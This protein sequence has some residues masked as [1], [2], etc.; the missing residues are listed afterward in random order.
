V[1][2]LHLGGGFV[3]IDSVN[4]E[5][6]DGR[7]VV[8]WDDALRVLRCIEANAADTEDVER[9]DLVCGG[10]ELDGVLGVDAAL[11]GV[12]AN[13]DFVR[14]ISLRRPPLAMR[15][16]ALTRSMPVMASVTGCST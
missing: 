15:S 3:A 8:G 13:F 5:L 10:G 2:A 16:C 14:R 1:G 4:D 9:G 6:G 12:A 11:D 7:V